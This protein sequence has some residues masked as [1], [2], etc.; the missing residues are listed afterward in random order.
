MALFLQQQLLV[1]SDALGELRGLLVRNVERSDDDAIDVSD[2]CRHGLGLCAQHV[3]I[4]VEEGE[5]VSAGGSAD[6]HL[7][8]LL[9]VGVLLDDLSPQHASGTELGNLHEVDAADA[10]VELDATG[11]FFCRHAG[12]DEFI[13]ILASPSQGVAKL[14]ID[15]SAAVVQEV[16]VDVDAAE[17]RQLGES[18]DECGSELQGRRCVLALL[19]HLRDGIEVNAALELS[20]VVA[21]L[22]EVSDESLGQ[23]NAVALAGAE[24]QFNAVGADAVE[25][26][27]KILLVALVGRHVETEAVDALVQDVESLG[28]SSLGIDLFDVLTDKPL[29]VVLLVASDVRELARQGIHRCQLIDILLTIKRLHGETFVGSPYHFLLVV[30]ALEVYLN[31]VAPFLAGRGGEVREEFFFTIC[32]SKLNV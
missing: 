29:V 21:L 18:S 12:F 30:S 23:L 3:D 31:L 20:E 28:V 11:S 10:E 9:V 26:G 7:G 14:L 2:S 17:L 13:E 22:G 1:A 32:H 19:E 6:V 27:C 15:V 5:V 4:A 16:G 25:Q 24:V 8:S